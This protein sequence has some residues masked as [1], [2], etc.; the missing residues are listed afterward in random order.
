MKKWVLAYV[1]LLLFAG[2]VWVRESHVESSYVTHSEA[3]LSE[4]RERLYRVVCSVERISDLRVEIGRCLDQV[5]AGRLPDRELAELQCHFVSELVHLKEDIPEPLSKNDFGTKF[6]PFWIDGDKHEL[7]L[8][9]FAAA[10]RMVEGIRSLR[11]IVTDGV[12]RMNQLP[13]EAI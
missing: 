5:H 13:R 4:Y 7:F 3:V 2:L 11:K 6:L 9:N 12:G 10:F 8:S 1:S